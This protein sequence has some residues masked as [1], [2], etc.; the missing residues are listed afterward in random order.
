MA[1]VRPGQPAPGLPRH[2]GR[3]RRRPAADQG[4]PPQ[5][6]L[7]PGRPQLPRHRLARRRARRLPHRE[8]RR[9]QPRLLRSSR[10]SSRARPTSSCS[11]ADFKSLRR[12]SNHG[13]HLTMRWQKILRF[14]IAVFVVVFAALLVAVSFRRGHEGRPTSPAV[15]TER[16]RSAIVAGRAAGTSEL[17]G[18][19][20]SPSGSSSSQHLTYDDGRYEVPR[21]RHRRAA[22]PERP[23]DH[24]STSQDADVTQPPGKQIGTGALQRRRQAHDERRD[25]GRTPP[26]PPTTTP[27][28]MT[29]N[30]RDR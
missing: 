14:A 27:T 24:H 7:P 3:D 25:H 21:R 20:R 4:T 5:D 6:D 11:V 9:R 28:Q 8:P 29:T 2:A 23:P 1:P 26:T 18:R 13:E 12:P 15:K 30:S 22:R 17:Q 19:A 10:T 16:R